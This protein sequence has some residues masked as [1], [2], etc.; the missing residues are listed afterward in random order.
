[1]KR[2]ITF[3]IFLLLGLLHLNANAF[4]LKVESLPL[5][6][7]PVCGGG[8]YD[9][10][11]E[12]WMNTSANTGFVFQ[13]WYDGSERLSQD[14]RF[15]Y[16][17]PARDVTLIARYEFSPGSP[18]DPEMPDTTTYYSFSAKVAPE[19]AGFVNISQNSYSQGASV[20]LNTSSNTGFVF[21]GWYDGDEQLST[22]RSY[23]YMMPARDVELTAQYEFSPDS[24]ADPDYTPAKYPLTI[25][26]SPEC[27]GYVS[28]ASGTKFAEGSN[29][30][31]SAGLNTGYLFDGWT[32]E[33]GAV[34]STSRNHTITMPGGPLTLTALFRFSPDNP[35]DPQPPVPARN[36]IYGSR[37]VAYP[38]G[39]AIFN[40]SL[41]NVDAVN[42]IDIDLKFP[43]G[44]VFDLEG[45]TPSNRAGM[46]TLS[47]ESLEGENE[48]RLHLRGGDVFDGANG[49]LVR[50]PVTVPAGVDPGTVY[51]ITLSSGVV[52]L[53]NGSQLSV[54]VRDGQLKVAQH[55]D[56]LPDSPDFR[57]AS[58]TA[59]EAEVMPGDVVTF[60]WT[61]VNDGSLAASGGWS[62]ALF[63]ADAAGKR[64]M[65]G[66]VFYDCAGLAAGQ[67][68]SRSA[69]LA[70]PRIP[71]MSG[72][73]N[74][75]VTVL[76]YL[77]SDEIIQLQANNT[78]IGEGF[79]ITLGQ[80]L[81]ITFP[82]VITEGEDTDIRGMLARTGRWEESES[83]TLSVD[84]A[85]P[86]FHVPPIV[87]IPREQS[88]TWFHATL[89]RNKVAD[90][91]AL[92][93]I[94]AAG[95]NY[96]P[97]EA[98][99]TIRDSQLPVIAV[100]L[101][102]DEATEGETVRLRTEIPYILGEELTVNLSAAAADRV[103]LPAI[104][105]IPAGQT[106]A[107]VEITAVDN[108]SVDGHVEVA[109]NA[110]ATGFANT[111]EYLTVYDNDMPE[112][113]M[114]LSPQEVNENAGPVAVR[115]V[116]NRTTNLDKRVTLWL[117]A[118]KT[119]Q[120]IFPVDRIVL[121][122]GV[123]SAEFSVG[124][125]D[126]DKVDGDR[127]VEITVSVYVSTCNCTA[128]GDRTGSVS[129]NIRILDNDGPS[130]GLTSSKSVV[131]EGDSEGT[132]ITLSR[133]ADF[134]KALT[135]SLSC[136]T[137]GSLEIPA[138]VVIQ[139]GAENV[140]FKV[141]A[142]I[143]DVIDDDRTVVVSAQADGYAASNLWMMV[144][145]R[146]L[147]DARISGISVTPQEVVAGGDVEV[148]FTLA[149]TGVTPLPAQMRVAIYA[150]DE[151]VQRVWL[152]DL[153][154]AGVSKEFVR[155]VK[156]PA[157]AGVCDIYAVA[158]YDKAFKEMNYSDNH[159]SHVRVKLTSPFRAGVK[160]SSDRIEKGDS[161]KITGHLEGTTVEGQEVEIYVVND[162]LRMTKKAHA[163]A[164]G[165]FVATYAPYMSQTGHF[166]V[167]ACYPGEG[168]TD[169]M[170]AFE[171][172]DIRRT[173]YSYV[174]CEAVAGVASNISIGIVNP[175]GIPLTTLTV[176]AV[177]APEGLD[178]VATSIESLAPGSK[179]ALALSLTGSRITEGDDWE[180]FSVEISSA[181]GASLSVPIYWYCRSAK[182]EL[183][184]SETLIEAD[185][186]DD[187]TV[188]YPVT[189]TNKGAGESGQLEVVLPEWMKCAGP[190]RLPSLAPGEETTVTLLLKPTSSMPLN[191]MVTG[192]L[193]VNCD[194]GKGVPIEYK[195]MPVSNRPAW[196]L[197]EACDEITYNTAE[198]PKV[199]GAKV[200]VLNPGT[201]I[202]VA[203]G[204]TGED[205]TFKA[206]LP[207]GYYRVS[208][209]ADKHDSWSG[210]VFLNPGKVRT[211]TADISFNPITIS[212]TVVPTEVEDE[213]VIETTAQFEVNLPVPVVHIIAPS[214]IEG[215][216]MEVGEAT[217]INVQM[218]N[219]GLMPALNVRPIFE[220]DNPE[221]KFEPLDYTDPFDLAP[222]QVVNIP[223]R[224]TRIADTTPRNSGG[225]HRGPAEDMYRSY[226][227]CMTHLSGVYE[228]MCGDSLS[229]NIP[230]LR[231]SMKM[232]A[233]AAT[234]G[235]I[236][237]G[238]GA[239][240][241]S[242]GGEG[243]GYGASSEW[244]EVKET[245]TICD[246]CDAEKAEKIID[247]LVGA[248]FAALDIF[249]SALTTAVNA[250][251]EGGNSV[252]Y[253]ITDLKG[254][255]IDNV[256]GYILSG[257]GTLKDLVANIYEISK[258]CENEKPQGTSAPRKSPDDDTDTNNPYFTEMDPSFNHS[259]QETFYDDSKQFCE[260][261]EAME[262]LYSIIMG[263]PVWFLD[264][265]E[266][267]LEYMRYV[268]A[269]EPGTVVS[270]DEVAERKPESVTFDQAR[271]YLD[272]I[273]DIVDVASVYESELENAI[274]T[275][276]SVDDSA[277]EAGYE[278][279]AVRFMKAYES[280]Q[281]KFE[282]LKS[283]SVCASVALRFSQTMTMTREAFRGT[284]EVFN[285]HEDTPMR[286]VRLNLTVT[287]P[288]GNLATG[289]EFQIN[290]ETLSGF[291][292][293]LDLMSGW[294]LAAGGRGVAEILFIPTR[295]AAPDVPIYWD[296][297]GTL[298]Y[299]DPFTDLEVTRKLFP[300][301][302]TVNPTPVLDLTYFLQRDVYS[303][304]PLT[305]D[306]VEQR[307][308]AEFALV[309]NNTGSG[310][311][312]NVRL[313]TRQPQIVDNEKGILL[314]TEFVSSQ[315]NGSER[316]MAL[317]G[318]MASDFGDIPSGTSAYAQWWFESSI[319]GHF[320]DYDVEATHV[321]SYGNP[322]LSLLGNVE[323]HELIRGI[324]DP[325][326]A[327]ATPRRLFLA[328]DIVDS[329]DRPDMVHYSDASMPA[330]LGTAELST[331]MIDR[332]SYK[333]HVQPMSPG[334]VYGS[335]EDPTGGRMRLAGIVRLSD[336]ASLPVDNCWQTAMTMRDGIKP[337]HEARLHI[338][339][340]TSGSDSYKLIFEARPTGILEVSMIG[341]VP[342]DKDGAVE[343]VKMVTVSFTKEVDKESFT[344][345]ALRLTLAGSRV[346]ISDVRIDS[347][348]PVDYTID[349][350]NATKYHG[351]YVFTVDASRLMDSEGYP[352]KDGK[353]V[354]WLQKGESEDGI[355]SVLA[356]GDFSI[357]PVPVRGSMTVRGSFDRI[358][359]IGVYDSAGRLVA[360][361]NDLV[362]EPLAAESSCY[363]VTL[364]VSHVPTGVMIVTAVTDAGVIHTRRVLFISE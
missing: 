74:P 163:V 258:P 246:P 148:T 81:I 214:K 48:W 186:P 169:E 159:S 207:T 229:K 358:L 301:T 187:T 299:I 260:G 310:D 249:W 134:D 36:I 209:S 288:D 132:Y 316:H 104:L 145:D 324:T 188:E 344:A 181:E 44:P 351:Y 40:V 329:E 337:L 2:Q 15:K 46:H 124:I 137:P 123:G 177:G 174:T 69:T 76:P 79:P 319:A 100:T 9:E 30:S 275:F 309:I 341:G 308:G 198:A 118:D 240:P 263:D 75:G 3:A 232:C 146:T 333:L 157:R 41:E 110:A 166:A 135:V 5:G 168:L 300:V 54:D 103:A 147:P 323:I 55:P 278:N 305:P 284:L 78:T 38:G 71:G 101:D 116:V 204:Y 302:V 314:E 87:I 28:P 345:D 67:S 283:N 256:L 33:Y 203:E 276:K 304:D 286:D 43:V 16:I 217:L 84:A 8:I 126:N 224:I 167:G 10:G 326:D 140:S 265:T 202:T 296:F 199:A 175:C 92:V 205:G 194:N 26:C 342:S 121:E 109:I 62:E 21:Q 190:V 269:L 322:D 125:L 156:L 90:P 355:L 34:I 230:A 343:P 14:K 158:N 362:L 6:S 359:R 154:P 228:V 4:E 201:D 56:V 189:I 315:L 171:I 346:D 80:R 239:G 294:H 149:S 108:N 293:D 105:V 182:G 85:D 221:W 142:P 311:A 325:E 128:A 231:M 328:N 236:V 60:N 22:S 53:D 261:W 211:V 192:R 25:L 248:Q 298:T 334:W 170:A 332:Y 219:E 176:K 347:I 250:H 39:A 313:V 152:Q 72:K 141:T 70:I 64:V 218:V 93:H 215:D 29:V 235:G 303:D 363:C 282:D 136:D 281:D 208:V 274:D 243:G 83:F 180:R 111:T 237:S 233:V 91:A 193:A 350:G 312:R 297:G 210:T 353:N 356:D 106:E 340:N 253:I 280:Y 173:D 107:S 197:V 120:V 273:L 255:I 244:T 97:V 213:Y 277:I 68:V 295:Y 19:G 17:M 112:L 259:W 102:P 195:V 131:A 264:P 52:Y 94:S 349:L 262:K 1:M 339:V 336:G 12:V 45:A 267:K 23:K 291:E 133:N 162:G 285:G 254:R 292:G 13:G 7:C 268:Y 321:T 59:D 130:L 206:E 238:S 88:A 227:G 160:L 196:I 354:A 307:E 113:T 331:E 20:S 200:M 18:A 119:D 257:A 49:A 57:V 247:K 24:P 115:G 223:V 287:D 122:S 65:L 35:G 138:S 117:T 242:P 212:Y 86:R 216:N 183:V 47:I 241:G 129:G 99:V 272:R 352:G 357:S 270:D 172:V 225:A 89:G 82:E 252:K 153:L 61:I 361:W 234:V 185:L 164:D 318:S 143:N 66:T 178:V 245:F 279:G 127:D 338:A 73:L 220:K 31:L 144:T 155:T 191:H 290:P 150:G 165:T 364:P 37:E 327:S 306:V 27:G 330:S 226:E 179:H 32:D 139:K 114:Q 360:R 96:E 77:A 95:D 184:S 348:A 63:L 266:D 320:I 335:I 50:I 42:G 98:A 251:L 161:V 289:H 51:D 271:M 11:T 317:G 222:H 58:V 151:I